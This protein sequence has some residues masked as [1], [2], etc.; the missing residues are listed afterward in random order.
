[1]HSFDDDGAIDPNKEEFPDAPGFDA[2]SLV[3]VGRQIAGFNPAQPMPA[4]PEPQTWA[5]MP[6]G[7]ASIGAISR[8]NRKG[9]GK[10][11]AN[12]EG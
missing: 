5:L 1:M 12:R 9:K 4:V 11:A 8:R 2:N 3:F 10:D 7:L 6:A